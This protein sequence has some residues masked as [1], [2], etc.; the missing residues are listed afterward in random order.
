MMRALWIAATL[1][2]SGA[3][4]PAPH[5]TPVAIAVDAGPPP[6][7]RP[8]DRDLP[9]LVERSLA[10]YHDIA[11]AFTASGDDCAAA[12]AQLG[13]LAMRDRDVVAAN[14][15]VL[16]D[17]RAAQLRAALA[18]HSDAFDAAARAIMQSPTL[19][20]CAQ[21]PAFAKAFDELFE[22]HP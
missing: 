6:D 2:C 7:A 16:H 15:A 18:P 19:S 13:Q 11:A 17:G 8:L 22:P 1:G 20:R 5:P 4:P 12:T 3:A 14:A 10:M 21:D 9:R